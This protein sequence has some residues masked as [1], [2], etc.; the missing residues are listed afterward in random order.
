MRDGGTLGDTLAVAYL[1]VKRGRGTLGDTNADPLRR[2][3]DNTVGAASAAALIAARAAI[4][5]AAPK[6][7][8]AMAALE[9]LA[10]A[11]PQTIPRT[12]TPAAQRHQRHLMSCEDTASSLQALALFCCLVM[13]Q[14]RGVE[15][16][17]GH[18]RFSDIHLD[19]P[20]GLGRYQYLDK[21][22]GGSMCPSLLTGPM[23]TDCPLTSPVV[24]AAIGLQW[25]P[26]L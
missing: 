17:N 5:H 13:F 21:S 6:L 8:S 15:L 2:T 23:R 11:T 26:R 14:S 9:D 20:L 10:R 18:T 7:S 1:R 3:W 19:L 25:A 22:Q 12:K 24:S 4:T 16:L